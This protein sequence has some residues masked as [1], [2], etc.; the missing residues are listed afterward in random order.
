MRLRVCTTRELPPGRVRRVEVA[1]RPPV[2]LYNLEGAF[3]ATADNCTHKW[4]SLAAGHLERGFIVCPW[5]GGAFDV[6]TGAAVAPP[7]V[8]ALATYPV[9]IDGDWL[10][11]VLEPPPG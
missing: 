1:G 2:A 8:Q 4:A 5:H 9:E 3:Y 6:R 11:L 7:C 10:V